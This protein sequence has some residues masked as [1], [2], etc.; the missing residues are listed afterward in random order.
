MTSPPR[1]L[2]VGDANMDLVLS[3]DTVPVF[4]QHEQFLDDASLV[5]GASAAITACGLARL[6]IS[7]AIAAVVGGDAFGGMVATGLRGCGVDTSPLITRSELQTG[8]TTILNTDDDR[9]ILTLPGAMA[10]LSGEDVRQA[11]RAWAPTHV[12]FAAYYLLPSLA[13]DLAAVLADIRAA[14]TTISVDT[15]ADP[16]RAWTAWGELVERVDVLLPNARELEGH[17]RAMGMSGPLDSLARQVA[18]LGPVVAVKNGAEGAIV[19]TPDGELIRSAGYS[20]ESVD[21]TG[22]GDSFNAGFLAAWLGGADTDVALEWA[23]AAGALAVRAI[24]G[25]AAQGNAAA[26]TALINAGPTP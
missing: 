7:T 16:R 3:G 19:A 10:T 23:C 24:G 2:V 12:H 25:T 15:N 21:T 22:A 11:V 5:L 26:I 14:G 17:A 8:L 20:S 6:G 4:G 18:D 9:A 1:V 13:Q